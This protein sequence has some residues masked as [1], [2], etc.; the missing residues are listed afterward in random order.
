MVLTTTADNR[1]Q[2]DVQFH[3]LDRSRERCNVV[4]GF[5]FFFFA[6]DG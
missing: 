2:G 6:V 1:K 3:E 4:K 5:F